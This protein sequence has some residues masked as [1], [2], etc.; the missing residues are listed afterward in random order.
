M[1]TNHTITSELKKKKK[2]IERKYTQSAELLLS[3]GGEAGSVGGGDLVHDD[4]AD[5]GHGH[6]AGVPG[7]ALHA[8]RQP[9]RVQRAHQCGRDQGEGRDPGDRVGHLVVG[10]SHLDDG[11]EEVVVLDG[12]PA[13]QLHARVAHRD[14][15]QQTVPRSEVLLLV[16]LLHLP[17]DGG[18]RKQSQQLI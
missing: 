10:Q 2:K 12:D 7:Q 16:V 3:P 5:P 6:A 13:Q 4:Q 18:T 14:Q 17:R 11:G 9:I 15:T 8:L 1:S